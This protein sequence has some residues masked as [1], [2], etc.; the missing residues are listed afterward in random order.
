MAG[1][2]Q[3][4]PKQELLPALDEPT[5]V[6]NT[7]NGQGLTEL[8]QTAARLYG[9]GFARKQIAKI[10]CVHLAGPLRTDGRKRTQQER[11]TRARR[12]LREWEKKQVFRDL[13]WDQAVVKLDMS[14]PEILVGVAQKAKRGRVDAARLALEV[15]GRHNPRGEE[16]PTNITVAIANI[17]RPD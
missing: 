15:T 10:L 4:A 13:V 3:E 11:E 6:L 1:P 8:Q 14:T 7:P 2:A 12:K 9:Q 16:K 17:P 5:E